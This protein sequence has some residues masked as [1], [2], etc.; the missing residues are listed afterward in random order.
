MKLFAKLLSTIVISA[1]VLS[2]YG[3]TF[4]MSHASRDF[5]E[6]EKELGRP[7]EE[8]PR[9][10]HGWIRDPKVE[11]VH[12]HYNVGDTFTLVTPNDAN[13]NFCRWRFISP[14]GAFLSDQE[15]IKRIEESNIIRLTHVNQEEHIMIM[16]YTPDFSCEAVNQIEAT[17]KAMNPGRVIFYV[18]NKPADWKK[19]WEHGCPCKPTIRKYIIDIIA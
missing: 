11:E 3:Y 1:I 2:S 9:I 14:Y 8:M 15:G 6:R 5:I 4:D 10:R 13:A 17:F 7:V 16:I 12:L 18:Q 19:S